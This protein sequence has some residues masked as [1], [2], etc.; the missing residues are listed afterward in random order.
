MTGGPTHGDPPTDLCNAVRML[1]SIGVSAQTINKAPEPVEGP[2]PPTCPNCNDGEG[3]ASVESVEGHCR[4][5]IDD[6]TGEW[7]H[8]DDTTMNWQTSTTTGWYCHNCWW[9]TNDPTWID[10]FSPESTDS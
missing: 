9:T 3:L 2:N 4:I 6:A 5:D 1:D 7:S 8:G 10:N